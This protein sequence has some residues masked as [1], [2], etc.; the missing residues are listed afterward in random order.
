MKKAQKAENMYL[1]SR[2][3]EFLFISLF[4]Y[5]LPMGLLV[6]FTMA[7]S[8]D[9]GNINFSLPGF[10]PNMRD[11]V[12]EADTTASGGQIQLTT[13]QIHKPLNSSIGRATYYQPMHLWDNSSGNLRLA[14]FTTHFSFSIDSLNESS[15]YR[16]DGLAF[17]LA[18]DGSK[19]PPHSGGG[20]LG[21]Q[22]CHSDANSKFVAVEFDT[23]PNPWDLRSDHVAIDLNSV[24]ASF[25]PVEWLWSDIENGGK[26]FNRLNSSAL[27]AILD[28]SQ[29]LPEWVTFGFSGATGSS[30][31]LHTIYS[32]N[33]SSNL[34]V[35]MN[36]TINPANVPPIPPFD[37]RRKK[38]TWL[39]VVL[40]IVGCISTLLL[41]LSLVWFFCRRR[42]Y[43]RM[44]EDGT[45]SFNVDVEMVTAPRKFSYK[46]LRLATN[47]FADE[48]L[49]GE[50]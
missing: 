25:S 40:A 35:S 18:P 3:P 41:V 8:I 38:E 42:K 19:I 26:D 4:L 15:G 28:L 5:T 44:R 46:E 36:K 39:R 47:N 23:Y 10:K 27:S 48:G 49:L 24:K 22:N 29:Y 45:I 2:K 43:R 14:D 30:I 31:E 16:G 50:G 11:I 6:P 33:F 13:N 7:A 1:K 12:F 21:L 37:P 20:C 9:D 17:F 34:Q 32:W